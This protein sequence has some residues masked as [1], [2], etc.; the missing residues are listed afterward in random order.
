MKVA[1]EAAQ[2]NPL[3]KDEKNKHC[4]STD[5]GF[6]PSDRVASSI[7][8][9]DAGDECLIA[10]EPPMKLTA[11][12]S[13]TPNKLP[14]PCKEVSPSPSKI[15]LNISES[16]LARGRR[17]L[18]FLLSGTSHSMKLMDT[19]S[20]RSPDS[21]S[22]SINAKSPLSQRKHDLPLIL[23]GSPRSKGSVNVASPRSPTSPKPIKTSAPSPKCGTKRKQDLCDSSPSKRRGEQDMNDSEGDDIDSEG[24][25]VDSGVSIMLEPGS[26][27]QA[28]GCQSPSKA[29]ES[30][31]EVMLA[32][33]DKMCAKVY[34][35]NLSL[36][37]QRT[38]CPLS[39]SDL[40]LIRCQMCLL[41]ITE[42]LVKRR[43]RALKPKKKVP[44]FKDQ[45]VDGVANEL[46]KNKD[47][48]MDK[49]QKLPL[50]DQGM[51]HINNTNVNGKMLAQNLRKH[52]G[53]N[54]GL[55]PV[56]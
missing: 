34:F 12:N 2:A 25:H 22:P 42:L 53:S 17:D 6:I 8:S 45:G 55:M 5:A 28:V 9:K 54:L 11:A 39:T 35:Q 23:F 47:K 41:Q 13:K 40:D 27:Q 19:A 46:A 44:L 36:L 43:L 18:S 3:V 31:L 4:E 32:L 51:F 7:C 21:P 1:L 50:D 29:E 33:T 16:P 52:H 24:D 26:S 15:S 14:S 56:I 20:P 30:A 48:L 10:E 49:S 38:M 37:H